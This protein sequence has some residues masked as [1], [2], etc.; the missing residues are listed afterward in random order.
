M[1][2]AGALQSQRVVMPPRRPDLRRP[3][4][5]ASAERALYFSDPAARPLKPT[6]PDA[7]DRLKMKSALTED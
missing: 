7:F 2:A 6:P 4:L 5:H 3:D 1:V